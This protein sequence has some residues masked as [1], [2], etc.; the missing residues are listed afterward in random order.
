MTVNNGFANL[1]HGECYN[2]HPVAWM[3]AWRRLRHWSMPSSIMLLH[4]NSR[5]KQM[6]PQIIHILHFC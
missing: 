5:I 6:P 2:G 4:S 1:C 3:Q